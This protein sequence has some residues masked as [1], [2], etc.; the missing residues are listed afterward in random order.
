MSMSTEI[1]DEVGHVDRMELFLSLRRVQL[2]CFYGLK[3]DSLSATWPDLRAIIDAIQPMNIQMPC[4]RPVKR[5]YSPQ[6]A[7]PADKE[8][9]PE[10]AS[11]DT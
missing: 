3:D 10:G 11:P 9:E 6:S 4:L 5:E 2:L 1:F 7:R 8:R